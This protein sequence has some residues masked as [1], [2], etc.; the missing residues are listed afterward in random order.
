MARTL[1]PYARKTL[2]SGTVAGL[3]SLAALAVLGRRELSCAAAPVN[4]PSH[5]VWGDEALK[6]RRWSWRYTALGVVIHQASSVWWA[7]LHHRRPPSA[8]GPLH[9]AVVTT[10]AAAAVDLIVTPKRFTPGFERQL[11]PLGLALVY[12][13]FAVGL[14]VATATERRA[15]RN[16][17]VSP[18]G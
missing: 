9:D 13:A 2:A 4:A 11:S 10:A 7:W 3:L 1:S 12:G 18:Q 16:E 14:A 6:Q 8:H 5:W 17:S 15:L